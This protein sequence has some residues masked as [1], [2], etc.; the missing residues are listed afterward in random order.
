MPLWQKFHLHNTLDSSGV[1]PLGWC[2]R[3]LP[4]NVSRIIGKRVEGVVLNVTSLESTETI[5]PYSSIFLLHYVNHESI[6]HNR[7]AVLWL[8]LTVIAC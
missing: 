2:P 7:T 6:L 3:D 1:N 4:G 8:I 5:F